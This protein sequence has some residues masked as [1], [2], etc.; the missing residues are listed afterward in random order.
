MDPHGP[1]DE[2]VGIVISE[3]VLAAIAAT[4]VREVE[5]VTALVPRPG[6]AARLLH[7]RGDLRFV[8]LA[9]AGAELVI[10]MTLRVKAGVNI[11]TLSCQAQTAVKKAMQD[12]AGRAVARVNL[13]IAG[14]D[15]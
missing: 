11:T 8:K 3:E 2:K 13:K 15:F 4:A 1:D 10:E 7:K 12:M 6:N 9:Q 5:G 14:A